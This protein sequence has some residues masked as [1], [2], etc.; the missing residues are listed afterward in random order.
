[1]SSVK[2]AE[3][4]GFVHINSAENTLASTSYLTIMF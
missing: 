3:A 2:D 4:R 1:M